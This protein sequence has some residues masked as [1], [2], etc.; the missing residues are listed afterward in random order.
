MRYAVKIHNP[1]RVKEWSRMALKQ[2][3]LNKYNTYCKMWNSIVDAMEIQ[4]KNDTTRGLFQDSSDHI[5]KELSKVERQ[6]N[7]KMKMYEKNSSF[8]KLLAY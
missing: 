6:L 2:K 7:R 8:R 4:I 3:V 5:L 1:E